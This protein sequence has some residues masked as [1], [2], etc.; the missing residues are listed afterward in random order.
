MKIQDVLALK[1]LD[2]KESQSLKYFIT[3]AH[4]H[5]KIQWIRWFSHL[6]KVIM[7]NMFEWLTEMLRK[8]AS[9]DHQTTNHRILDNTSLI[10]KVIC[11]ITFF[12]RWMP[13]RCQKSTLPPP[14]LLLGYK[15]CRPLWL[16]RLFL[17]SF[18]KVLTSIH[19][20]FST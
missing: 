3:Q 20:P 1:C 10:A 14:P 12:K 17:L 6:G 8:N 5:F 9:C 15:S 7:Y 11:D 4:E 19:W 2:H 13:C 16:S 18:I